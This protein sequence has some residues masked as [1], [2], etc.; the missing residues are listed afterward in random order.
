MLLLGTQFNMAE[1]QHPT[2]IQ[3]PYNEIYLALSDT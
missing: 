3:F 2:C 1:L